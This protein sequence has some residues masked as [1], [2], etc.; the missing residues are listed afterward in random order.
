MTWRILFAAGGLFMLVGGPRHPAGTMVQMLQHPD[1]LMAHLLVTLGYASMLAG[2]IAF[3]RTP[4]N[5]PA[6]T[7]WTKLAIIGTALMTIEMVMHTA[8]MVDAEHLAAGHSTPVFT[9]HLVMAVT[10][11]PIFAV[12]SALF[13]I[14]GMRERAIG[15]V[16]YSWIGIAG[17]LANGAAPVLVV[18]FGIMQA[19]ILFP[20]MIG[21]A[22]WLVLAAL[23]PRSHAHQRLAAEGI[24]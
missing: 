18:A 16:W 19:R 13:F 15:S 17:T 10:F 23:T 5:T 8:A 11:Y 3:S 2:L 12:L 6:M 20:M 7:R 21:I 9:T 1:W 4:D 14:Q 22:I 24:R